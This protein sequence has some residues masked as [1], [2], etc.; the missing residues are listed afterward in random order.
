MIFK[1]NKAQAA[2]PFELF[3]AVIIMAFVVVMGY[4]VLGTVN[5]EVCLNNVDKEMIK[6]KIALEDTANRNS[7]QAF[8]FM[9]PTACFDSKNTIM[10]IDVGKDSTCASRCGSM[11]SEC[12]IM[13]FSNPDISNA[14]KQKC[15]DLPQYT[16]FPTDAPLCDDSTLAGTGFSTV[17]PIEGGKAGIQPGRYVVRNVSPTGDTY[18]K[19]CVW[20]NA[21]SG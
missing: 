12:Y 9:P 16:S 10:K 6:F 11:L 19:I 20:Y 15:I 13:T 21:S 14:F 18:K 1:E 4:T 5:T 3:V 8:S 17:N 7:S 2:A